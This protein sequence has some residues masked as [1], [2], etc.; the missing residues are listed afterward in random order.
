MWPYNPAC[1][2]DTTVTEITQ[3]YLHSWEY[4]NHEYHMFALQYQF[5]V[6]V[7][8]GEVLH[9][10]GPFKG[11]AAGIS[12]AKA[13]FLPLLN[14]AIDEKVWGDKAYSSN[15]C[16]IAPTRGKRKYIHPTNQ[17]RNKKIYRV[18]QIVERS[19]LRVKHFARVTD[20]WPFSF[21]MHQKA[22]FAS[23]KLMNLK[24]INH[25]LN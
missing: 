13:H 25:P 16:F 11:A 8:T 2:I 18:R 24:L 10:C 23:V 15:P 19:I 3:P 5:V 14:T 17:L 20:R 22:M 6:S 9:F 12:I 4:W 1:V 7:G 21:K